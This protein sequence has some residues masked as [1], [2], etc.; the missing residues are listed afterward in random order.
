MHN[1][2]EK[3]LLAGT[4]AGWLGIKFLFIF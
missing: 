2:R 4:M 1:F 3:S